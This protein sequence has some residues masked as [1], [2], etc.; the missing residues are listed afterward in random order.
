MA[1]SKTERGRAA[2]Q[3][4]SAE[5]SLAERRAL[6][7]CDGVRSRDDIV[8][9]LGP[10]ALA[11]L[12]RLLSEGYLTLED[13]KAPRLVAAVPR[14]A[15]APAPA[16][17]PPVVSPPH[18]ASRR[19]LAVS[20]MYLLDMLQLQRD[21]ESASLR[22]DIQTSPSEDELIYRMMQGL[23]HLQAIATVSY[24]QRVG[25]RL[26]EILPEA[27]LPKLDQARAAW[28]ESVSAAA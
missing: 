25:N 10:K 6:I 28:L 23:R 9:M 5:M 24:A 21:A 4:H 27:Y 11:A 18:A 7:L 13:A 17:A 12:E 1:I 16:A 2:L 19:S 8:A 22:A 15:T 3:S 26:A 20:K 14:A